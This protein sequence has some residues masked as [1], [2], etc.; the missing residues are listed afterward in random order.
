MSNTAA[1]SSTAPPATRCPR[2]ISTAEAPVITSPI[3]VSMLGVRPNRRSTGPSRRACALTQSWNLLV[4]TRCHPVM[5]R[6]VARL[7]IDVE[8]DVDDARPVVALRHAQ[9]RL[10]ELAPHG[11]AGQHALQRRRPRQR[12]TGGDEQ[13]VVAVADD[14]REALDR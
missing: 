5:A 14:L 2:A 4:N 11:V 8:D 12:L 13:P 1:S 7:R 6:T 10:G 3:M 9:P